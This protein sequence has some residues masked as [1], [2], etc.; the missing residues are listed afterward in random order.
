MRY[1]QEPN[2]DFLAIADRRDLGAT[3]SPSRMSFKQKL[4]IARAAAI[5]GQA[6]SACTCEVS[7]SY[8]A[9]CMRIA[10]RNIPEVWRR[11]L[12]GR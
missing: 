6:S 12:Q 10:F 9:A 8:L 4:Y 3:I 1:Y 2:G 11:N 7:A 5:A